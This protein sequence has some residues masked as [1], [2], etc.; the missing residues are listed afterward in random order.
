MPLKQL[1][2]AVVEKT[3]RV[4]TRPASMKMRPPAQRH[5]DALKRI[6]DRN[7]PDYV[8]YDDHC[9]GRSHPVGHRIRRLR[10]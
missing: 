4:L 9:A 10:R 2:A 1:P 5:F 3:R 8:A 6:L 7:D